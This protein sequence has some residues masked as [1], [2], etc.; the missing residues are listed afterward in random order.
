MV[1]VHIDG[2]DSQPIGIFRENVER[3]SFRM[4]TQIEVD[5]IGVAFASTPRADAASDIR[6][7][8]AIQICDD[9][10][11]KKP[12]RCI[13]VPP[14][15]RP[16]AFAATV[17]QHIAHANKKRRR[18]S[19][20]PPDTAR[21]IVGVIMHQIVETFRNIVVSAR[22]LGLVILSFGKVTYLS[23]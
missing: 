8:I 10:R 3:S 18:K 11:T 1:A 12:H 21:L 15:G 20:L 7:V 23:I 9:S 13:A 14:Y 22:R 4:A 2:F 19:W 17:M 6:D 5:A 16:A